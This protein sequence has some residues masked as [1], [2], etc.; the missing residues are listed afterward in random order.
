MP[1]RDTEYATRV[2]VRPANGAHKRT[3]SEYRKQ[4]RLERQFSDGD[5]D[6]DGSTDVLEVWFAGCHCGVSLL[7]YL[8]HLVDRI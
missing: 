7:L 5:P 3:D 6:S 4:R 2:G 8:S 1:K